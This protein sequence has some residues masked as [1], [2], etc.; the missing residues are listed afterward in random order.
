MRVLQLISS[1]GYYGAENMLLNL[2]SHDARAIADNV[3]AVFDNRHQQNLDLYHRALKKGV[4]A[5]LISCQG[6]ADRRAVREIRRLVRARGI[7]VMHTHGYKA[8]IY[9]FVAAR[10]EGTP[11]VATCHNWLAGGAALA[12]YNF[13]DRMALKQ[14]DTVC[15]V[16]PP[17]AEKLLSLGLRRERVTVIPN[18]IDVHAFDPG[19]RAGGE[20]AQAD[21]KQVLG[22][23]ARLDL[24]K[25]FDYLLRAVASLRGVFPALRLLIVG[26]GPD[27]TAIEEMVRRYDLGEVVTL[28][29]QQT[30]MP[31][32]YAGIDI[33]VLPSLNEGLPMTLLEAM[34]AGKPV[35][36][37]RVGAISTVIK[38]QETGLLIAAADEAALTQALRR[39]L[40]DPELRLRLGRNAR[41]HVEQN[42]TTAAMVQKYRTVYEEVLRRRSCVSA[43]QVQREQNRSARKM[44]AP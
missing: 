38:D 31:A 4:N 6:R 16:S 7:D 9:G 28:A 11:L 21:A 37:S 23:V 17:I 1:G 35:V 30:D 40:A 3:L 24:Q 2:V 41:A 34:A 25:G 33:F 32:V 12:T 36:A 13:L 18:G 15:A 43:D 27:R 10:S 5:E 29:G 22:I 42:F 44:P 26:E 20:A 14:F 39:L 19:S 8:D